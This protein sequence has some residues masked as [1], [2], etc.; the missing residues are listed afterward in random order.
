[1][2]D[3]NSKHYNEMF[4]LAELIERINKRLYR[5]PLL[6]SVVIQGLEQEKVFIVQD[7]WHSQ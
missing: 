6:I 5:L 3:L 7:D 1:M 4:S 2:A